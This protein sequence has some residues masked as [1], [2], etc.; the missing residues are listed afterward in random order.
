M[1]RTVLVYLLKELVTKYPEG[2]IIRIIKPLYRI[3]EAGVHWFATYQGHHCKE[4]DM[5]TSTYDPCLLIINIGPDKFG[6]V[7]LQTDDTLAIRISIFSKAEDAVLY[8]AN[9]RAKPKDRLSDEM[10]LK[11]NGCTLTL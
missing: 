9:F 6:I 11:F 7:G 1:F 5:A 2:I 3:A 4:L 10:S 8:K